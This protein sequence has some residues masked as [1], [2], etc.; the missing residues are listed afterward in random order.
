MAE[1]TGRIS[2]V[3]LTEGR[4]M[5]THSWI[6]TT[7]VALALLCPS[8]PLSAGR[9]AVCGIFLSGSGGTH[10]VPFDR[11]TN[12]QV[13]RIP[14]S[15]GPDEAVF[16]IGS[17]APCEG[18]A[19]L[20]SCLVVE[21]LAACE[22]TDF[23]CGI[24]VGDP[25]ECPKWRS[26]DGIDYHLPIEPRYSLGDSLQLK[27]IPYFSCSHSC[28]PLGACLWSIAVTACGDTTNPAR[29]FSWG[30]LKEVW[31]RERSPRTGAGSKGQ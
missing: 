20:D 24:V 9:I 31:S 23:G 1:C 11:Y 18:G 13:D 27:G 30:A 29:T 5:S 4:R 3:T 12:Y 26:E 2:V 8:S 19:Y 22:A 21:G 16:V 17:V 14:D 10:F 28:G 15:V 25:F 6:A 7:S